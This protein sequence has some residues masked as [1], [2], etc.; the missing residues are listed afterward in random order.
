MQIQKLILA[1]MMISVAHAED[2]PS[3]MDKAQYLAVG[4]KLTEHLLYMVEYVNAGKDVGTLCAQPFRT[5]YFEDDLKSFNEP[6]IQARKDLEERG[7]TSSQNFPY[8]RRNKPE[9]INMQQVC[10]MVEKHLKTNNR[11][12]EPESYMRTLMTKKILSNPFEVNCVKYID[13]VVVN[14]GTCSTKK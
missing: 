6:L 4:L 7:I 11:C 5:K 9:M 13:A 10:Q 3:C 8:L 14:V 12:M 1:L 2:E